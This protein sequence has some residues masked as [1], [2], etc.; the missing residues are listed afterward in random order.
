MS[1]TKPIVPPKIVEKLKSNGTFA[2]QD[3]YLKS[4][5]CPSEDMISAGKRPMNILRQ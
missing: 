2:M 3:K 1:T 4:L 5:E